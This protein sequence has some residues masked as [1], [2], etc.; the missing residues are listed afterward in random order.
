[1][2][3]AM[4]KKSIDDRLVENGYAMVRGL[5]RDIDARG[6]A[7]ARATRGAAA[8]GQAD[9]RP[10]HRHEPAEMTMASAPG[11]EPGIAGIKIPYL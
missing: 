10:P 8:R 6:S 5:Q 7:Q 2:S 9:A 1:M 3:D 11:F 4:F